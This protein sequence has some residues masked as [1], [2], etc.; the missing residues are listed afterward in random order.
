MLGLDIDSIIK[1]LNHPNAKAMNGTRNEL[2]KELKKALGELN[3][4][5]YDALEVN[6]NETAIEYLKK[7]EN[8]LNVHLPLTK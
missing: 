2:V 3:E 5:A 6:S 1:Q 4:K 7:A 8:I